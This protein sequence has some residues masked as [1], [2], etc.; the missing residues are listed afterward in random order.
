MAKYKVDMKITTEQ[1][2]RGGLTSEI[3]EADTESTAI[4]LALNKAKS[5]NN[6]REYEVIRI[7]KK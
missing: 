7:Q 6:K 2:N 1:G 3:V 4:M 5:R